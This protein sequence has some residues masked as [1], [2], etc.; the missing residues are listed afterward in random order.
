MAHCSITVYRMY[1]KSGTGGALTVAAEVQTK[2]YG[3]GLN[4][5]HLSSSLSKERLPEVQGRIKMGKHL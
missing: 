4:R 2:T 3:L 5:L 1:K